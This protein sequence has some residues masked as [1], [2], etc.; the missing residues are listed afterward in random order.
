MRPDPQSR[1]SGS[2][3][4]WFTG[5]P[6]SGKSTIAAELLGQLEA[7]G[8]H[9]ARLESDALRRVMHG[10]DYSDAG[11]DSFYGTLAW[12]AGLLVGH[13]VPVVIDATANRRR[14][15]DSLRS[16]VRNFVEVYVDTPLEVCMKR[17]PKGLYRRARRERSGE[18]PGSGADYEPPPDP[19]VTVSGVDDPA[20]AA[21]RVVALLADRRYLAS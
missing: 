11:R 13:G 3:V 5:L 2:F 16:Q 10:L 19:E 15:R 17:D 20:Q 1:P 9:C 18:L 21:A 7:R 14:Y 6:A 4:V 12:I 8:V